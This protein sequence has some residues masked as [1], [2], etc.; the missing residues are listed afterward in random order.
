MR[1]LDALGR[2]AE[3]TLSPKLGHSERYEAYNSSVLLSRSQPLRSFWLLQTLGW[4]AYSSIVFVDVLP[5]LTDRAPVVYNA[6]FVASLFLSSL[7]LRIF[8]RRVWLRNTPWPRAMLQSGILAA[9]MGVPCGFLAEWSWNLVRGNSVS[10]RL[11]FDAWGGIVFA[12][13]VLIVWS[14]LYLGI[15]HYDA[16]QA[17]RERAIQAE[18]LAREARLQALRYQLNP[19]FLFNTLNAISTL[20]TRGESSAANQMLVQLA[21]FLRST[22]D[23]LGTQEIPLSDEISNTQLYLGIEKARLGERLDLEFSIQPEARRALVPAL[24]LQPLVENAIRHGIAPSP[25]G[26]KLTIKTERVA[27]RLRVTVF[28]DGVGARQHAAQV[29]RQPHGLGLSN[30]IERLRV[31][32]DSNHRLVVHLP[33]EGG[34]RVEIELPYHAKEEDTQLMLQSEGEKAC[35]L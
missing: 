3:G 16:F 24:L 14:A 12:A 19:H 32:Y 11:L 28:D 8:C 23:G 7:V 17:E 22:L 33:P 31:L 30:T 13:F 29:G 21:G 20:V 26:G 2:S 1:Q 4:L 10:G 34:C 6:V 9:V 18:A 15:K 5:R 25:E 35:A 27:D